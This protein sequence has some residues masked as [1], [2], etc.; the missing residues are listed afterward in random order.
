MHMHFLVS[1]FALTA[2]PPSQIAEA[3]SP[4]FEGFDSI[5]DLPC[6]LKNVKGSP[7]QENQQ[8]DNS[9][10]GYIGEIL[11]YTKLL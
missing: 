10:L 8:R 4:P 5:R 9:Q 7:Y 6:K 11:P 1:G 3:S 2:L